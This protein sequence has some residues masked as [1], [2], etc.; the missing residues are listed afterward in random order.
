MKRLKDYF[1]SEIDKERYFNDP[2]YRKQI[3]QKVKLREKVKIITL[4]L[5]LL[6][7]I[8]Y[9]IYLVAGLPSLQ[10]LENPTP[11]LATKVY[12]Y[13]GELLGQFYI[14]QRAYTPIDSIPKNLI[15]AL[16]AT[17]DRKF[18]KHWG[19]DLDRV[20]KA[21]VKNI[22]SFRIREGASTIT[23]Q[24]ARNLYLSQELSLTRKI[25]EAITAIQIER[26]YTK[27]EIL[28]MYLNIAYFGMSA[29]GVESASFIY[30]GKSPKELTLAECA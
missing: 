15:N 17:E 16:I 8:A 7:F 27:E 19:I 9:F 23:Q 3:L 29:Y 1:E 28:E 20:L 13:D 22:L 5:L 11:E 2:E 4:T 25:R 21:M 26:N 6:L 10:Q 12:S 24:L 30:F 14:K 18:Y